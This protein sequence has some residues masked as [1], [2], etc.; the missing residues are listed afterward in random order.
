M[1]KTFIVAN[2]KSNMTS[3]EANSWL[4]KFDVKDADILNKEIII[5][6]PFSLLSE[7]KSYFVNHKF[8]VK[9]GAQDIS[10]FDEGSYTGGVNGKQ[11]QEF[12]EFVIV[13]HS[14]R[15]KNFCENEETVNSKIS[16][17]FKFGLMPIA[18]VSSIDQAKALQK[19]SKEG[20][21]IVAYEPIFAIGTG[22]PDTPENADAMAKNIKDILGG[23]PIL[24]G[25]SVNSRNINEFLKMPNINGALIGKASLD[26]LEFLQISKNA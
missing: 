6:P 7:L 24:Y 4:E 12:A 22:T 17:C 13:G 9:V 11:I 23:I 26:P 10:S 16:Q 15:R 14:E 8:T 25:G 5:C 19:I 18:C 21:M 20:S 3:S 2:W 1:K